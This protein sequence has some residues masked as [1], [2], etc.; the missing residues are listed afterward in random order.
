MSYTTPGQPQ[1]EALLLTN[2]I[3]E[4]LIG[5]IVAIN[6]YNNHI[7]SI[8][9]ADLRMLLYHIM[10]DEKRHYGMLLNLLRKF[11]PVQAEKALE[12]PDH[13]H[14]KDRPIKQHY[15]SDH[16]DCS[17]VLNKIREDIKGELE[18]VILYEDI[19]SKITDDTAKNIIKE[20]TDDEKEHSEELTLA[21]IRLDK[22][23]YHLD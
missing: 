17:L 10:E 13:V 23:N 3:R 5:E 18:A 6:Q 2:F 15:S 12:V 21:L 4:A 1:G 14:I 19:I 9:L 22:D 11:D 7:D 16:K 8:N 20:I